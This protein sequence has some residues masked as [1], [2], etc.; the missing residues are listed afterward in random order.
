MKI[1]A[2][3]KSAKI[4]TS[5]CFALVDKFVCLLTH[6][7]VYLARG[8]IVYSSGVHNLT[9]VKVLKTHLLM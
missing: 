2:K 9:F 7:R 5:N 1:K 3:R 4:E 8:G 6:L